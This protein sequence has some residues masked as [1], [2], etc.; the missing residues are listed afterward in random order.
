[1]ER[2]CAAATQDMAARWRAVS[3]ARREGRLKQ[4]SGIVS[5]ERA[6][7]DKMGRIEQAVFTSARTDRGAGYQVVA[8]SRGVQ[9]ADRRELAIWGPS[10]DSLLETGTDVVSFNFFPLPS[11]AFCISRT[12]PVGSEYSGRG[13][14]RVYTHC[15]VA[16]PETLLQFANH[17]LAL[18]R[19]AAATGA[20][21]VRAELPSILETLDLAETTPTV[22]QASLAQ[23]VQRV[24]P[25]HMARL[26]QSALEAACTAIATGR[27]PAEQLIAGLLDCLP[28]ECRTAISFST[29]LRYSSRRPF[30]IL[31]LP[32]DQAARRRLA[33]QPNVTALD[34]VAKRPC[35]DVLVN[36]WA[37]LIERVLSKNRIGLLADELS[38]PR[39]D[40]TPDNLP[41]L[42]LQLLES[43]EGEEDVTHSRQRVKAT[44]A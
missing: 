29:G 21:D 18:A 19:A 33:H 23:L 15:L 43:L 16:P 37:R 5:H 25:W 8:T 1:L 2:I 26:V 7:E 13:G 31:R 12:T 24:G 9:E 41:A 34:W 40:L 4:S 38:Q 6:E 28:L 27:V 44:L 17:P 32:S 14:T 22:D 20:L 11:G 35:G 10:H 3:D 36:N 42:G 30:C 39:P